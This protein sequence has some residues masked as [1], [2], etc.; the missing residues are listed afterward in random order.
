MCDC[1]KKAGIVDALLIR[2]LGGPLCLN[3]IGSFSDGI[4][5]CLAGWLTSFG[6]CRLLNHRRAC[7][8]SHCGG[9]NAQGGW[10]TSMRR[11]SGFSDCWVHRQYLRI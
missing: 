3:G 1:R 11:G 8:A 5:T 2:M 6:C 4:C 10:R 9:A 7:E